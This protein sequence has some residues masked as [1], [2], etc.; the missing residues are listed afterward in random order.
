MY[1]YSIEYFY[2]GKVTELVI[3]GIGL[4]RWTSF[5]FFFKI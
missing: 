5:G 3:L 4:V 2:L 1:I